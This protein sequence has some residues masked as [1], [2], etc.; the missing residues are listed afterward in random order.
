MARLSLV[1]FAL[2]TV[3][4]VIDNSYAQSWPDR[5]VRLIVPFGAGGTSDLAARI[6]APGLSD[7]FGQQ[8]IV[9]NHP[10]ATGVIGTEFVARAP[11]D[12]YTFL[13]ATQPQLA[14]IPTMTKTSYDPVKDFAPISD[15]GSAPF[16]LVV[17]PGLPV[18]TLSEFL[19]Y[20]RSRPRQLTYAATG[21]GAINHLTMAILLNRAGVDM[22]PVLY[23]GGPGGLMDVIAGH[24]DAYLAGIAV[25]IPHAASGAVRPLAVTSERRLP[26]F[27]QVPT[28]AESGL[29]GFKRL[30]WT[31]L[32]ARAGTPKDIVDRVAKETARI[33]R[34][35]ASVQRLATAGVD[36]LG[37][38]P[39][40]FA[41]TIA[42][43]IAFWREAVKIAGPQPG[44]QAK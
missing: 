40:E 34:E 37:D 36:A 8:F 31:G 24:V 44:E 30:L 29:P 39:E 38:S 10:G 43:D 21:F 3:V 7:A 18:N 35:P 42:E 25:V 5:T 1:A 11:P 16:V 17:R 41:A 2:L 15:V 26:Q 23:K 19:D 13:M 20:A 27:P 9:E 4:A 28:L 32:L 22:T 14:I 33:V 6:I 12:G